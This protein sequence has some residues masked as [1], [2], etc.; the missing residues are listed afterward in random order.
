M[1]LCCTCIDREDNSV[2]YLHLYASICNT[3]IACQDT[4]SC[5]NE[6]SSPQEITKIGRIAGISELRD[7][8][9]PLLSQLCI[10]SS[11]STKADLAMR[12]STVKEASSLPHTLHTGVL[13][14][15][16]LLL[17]SCD[18]LQ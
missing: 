11:G 18:C 17:L 13:N 3:D 1:S 6:A 10:A 15:I 7:Q 2:S 14:Q 8:M 9:S 4:F 16:K 12:A 5:E